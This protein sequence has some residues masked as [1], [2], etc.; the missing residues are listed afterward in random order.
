MK[1]I[2]IIINLALAFG[3]NSSLMSMQSLTIDLQ[4]AW[5][6]EMSQPKKP[7][8]ANLLKNK[9]VLFVAGLLGHELADIMGNYY[10]DN[11]KAAEKD[12]GATTS[13]YSPISRL[14]IPENAD[15][16]YRLVMLTSEQQ[17]KPL[18]LVGHSKGAAEI[19]YMLFMHPELI[20]SGVVD[21]VLLLQAA[22]GGSPLAETRDGVLFNLSMFLFS[23]NLNT[24]TYKMSK[25]HFDNA[26]ACYQNSLDIYLKTYSDSA[27]YKNLTRADL[28]REISK[29]VF[30]VGS[31]SKGNY[32]KAINILLFFMQNNLDNFPEAHDALVPLSSQFFPGF[33]VHMG[34]LDAD[35]ADL[36]V[37]LLSNV[38]GKGRRVL[39]RL[40]FRLMAQ[41]KAKS[42][43]YRDISM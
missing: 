17:K 12:L 34:V 19:L 2:W 13:Y 14:S 42:E 6:A 21:Q 5:E 38:S 18:D 31:K 25:E 39:T 4:E 10:L 9:H 43:L 26:F 22:I 40:L 7:E 16:L 24:L 35:H 15:N 32:S 33:G 30:F 36:T 8:D 3:L 11:I 28:S 1:K 29:K 37:S 41:N 20:L 27:K 23:P